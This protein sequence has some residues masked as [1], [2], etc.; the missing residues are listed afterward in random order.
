MTE[1]I[2]ERYERLYETVL[3]PAAAD[4]QSYIANVLTGADRID[5]VSARAKSPERFAGKALN[6]DESGKLKYSDPISQIQDQIGARITVL[7][8]SDVPIVKSIIDE[9]FPAIEWQIKQP[10]SAAEFGYFGEHFILRL[11]DDVIPEGTEDISPKFFELQIKTIFQHAWSE[12]HHDIGYKAPRPLTSHER[13]QMAFSAAQSWGAD[14]IFL[15]LADGL[16][17]EPDNDE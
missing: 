13:R 3:I 12:C 2:A 6:L 9:H 8:L 5:S 10:D 4:L 1:N 17:I 15:Q 7:Y 16:I 14:Q 11:P